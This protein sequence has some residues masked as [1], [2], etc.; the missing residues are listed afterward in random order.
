MVEGKGELLYKIN[1]A[2]TACEEA[3]DTGL[4]C[5]EPEFF[6]PRSE[7]MKKKYTLP[8]Q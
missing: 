7:W 3:G 2:E 8:S 6:Y 4:D 5:Y 1:G